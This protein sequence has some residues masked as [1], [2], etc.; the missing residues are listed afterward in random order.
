MIIAV[1]VVAILVT[2]SLNVTVSPGVLVEV[3]SGYIVSNLDP[4]LNSTYNNEIY[5][6]NFLPGFQAGLTHTSVS[7]SS[8]NGYGHLN[9]SIGPWAHEQVGLPHFAVGPQCCNFIEVPHTQQFRQVEWGDYYYV[10]AGLGPPGINLENYTTD[11]TSPVDVG[12]RTDWNWSVQVALNWKSPVMMN[13]GNEWGAIRIAVTQFVPNA[14]GNLVFTLLNFWMDTNSS[15]LITASVDG[16]ERGIAPPNIVAYY[17]IQMTGSGNQTIT[18]N[19]SPYLEDTLRV[20]GLET[21]QSQHPVISYV[22]LNVEG[23]NFE[24]NTT[25]WS[26]KVIAQ[27]NSSPQ[28]IPVS[29]V[30]ELV[31]IVA[32]SA[33]LFYLDLRKNVSSRS[34]V[35]QST[36]QLRL[37][38]E[39]QIERSGSTEMR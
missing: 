5:D 26:F 11:F 28:A 38:E 3:P 16:T 10:R 21:V 2:S 24:W 30:I 36:G 13:P 17:P 6:P 8:G 12:L 29:Q 1:L 25:L 34:R 20:L 31:A 23:Y 39:V 9:Y 35:Q 4:T 15:S 33:T 27:P 7:W 18:I 37:R 19:I 32:V 22:Y 14:P